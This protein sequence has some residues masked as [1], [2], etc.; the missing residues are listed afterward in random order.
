MHLPTLMH[1]QRRLLMSMLA[2]VNFPDGLLRMFGL[3]GPAGVLL[4]G[5]EGPGLLQRKLLKYRFG[6]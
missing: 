5:P 1:G 3:F 4:A 6:R 2:A